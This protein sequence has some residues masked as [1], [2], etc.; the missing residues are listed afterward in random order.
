MVCS[1]YVGELMKKIKFIFFMS[2]IFVCN[3]AIG[4]D[5]HF[6]LGKATPYLS[7]CSLKNDLHQTDTIVDFTNDVLSKAFNSFNETQKNVAALGSSEFFDQLSYQAQ[8]GVI[9]E[10]EVYSLSKCE[11]YAANVLKEICLDNASEFTFSKL[12]CKK[13][14]KYISSSPE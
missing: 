13:A 2:I 3:Y 6:Q 12:T 10:E 8:L 5:L 4:N 7:V 11:R 14:K 1:K 9:K